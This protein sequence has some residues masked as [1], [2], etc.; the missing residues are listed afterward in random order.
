MSKDK[1]MKETKTM[2]VHP[3]SM[4]THQTLKYLKSTSNHETDDLDC[5][6]LHLGKWRQKY[7]L[8]Q[9]NVPSMIVVHKTSKSC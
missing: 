3:R 9:N 4:R 1:Y 6:T 8:V 5:R 7:V 2:K